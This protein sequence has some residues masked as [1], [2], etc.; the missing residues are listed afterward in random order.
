MKK[1]VDYIKASYR[2]PGKRKRVNRKGFTKKQ[3]KAITRESEDDNRR[4]WLFPFA[5]GYW[6]RNQD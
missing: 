1:I 4:G 6:S 3:F 2:T 5:I